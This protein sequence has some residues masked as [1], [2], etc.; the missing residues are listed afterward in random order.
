MVFVN[1]LCFFQH[2]VAEDGISFLYRV[3]NLN[4]FSTSFLFVR[5]KGGKGK[6][7]VLSAVGNIGDQVQ[8]SS[9]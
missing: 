2:V 9:S 3:S 6:C 5:N 1:H 8:L 4:A 7:R